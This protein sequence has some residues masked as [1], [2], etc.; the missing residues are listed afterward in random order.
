MARTLALAGLLVAAGAGPAQAQFGMLKKLKNKV[1]APDSATRATDSLAQIAKGVSPD[2]VKIGRGLLAR[3]VSAAASASNKL[4]EKTGISAKDAALAATGIG[5][6]GLI[7]RKMGVDPMSMGANLISNAKAGAKQKAMNAA[8][9]VNAVGA[10]PGMP[11]AAALQGMQAKMMQAGMARGVGKAGAGVTG[12][13]PNVG[14]LGMA[15]TGYTQADAQALVAF[16]QEMMQVAMAASAGDASAKARLDAWSALT[17]KHEGEIQKLA[18][19]AQAGDMAS[20]QKLQNMQLTM[21]KE[22]ASTGSTKAKIMRAV[23]P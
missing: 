16:Q 2:S 7:A 17:V 13:M 20:M 22:W 19:T 6:T 10:I 5:A 23:K 9:G 14:G 12:K 21:M 8:T 4:E 1:S 15:G 11:N 18:L 3:G